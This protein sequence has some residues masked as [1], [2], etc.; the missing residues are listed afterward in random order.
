M[1]YTGTIWRPPYEASSLLLE[2][3]AG[4]THH[5]CKFCTLYDGLLFRFRM[6]PMEDIEA[7]L[8]EAQGMY[9]RFP[10]RKAARTFLTGAN[11]FVLEYGRL[12]E[13][14]GLVHKYFPGMGSIGSFARVTD[15]ALK[16][17]GELAAL[18]KAGYD[19]LT[20]GIETADD[21]ALRFMDKGYLAA[22]ILKQCGRLDQAGIRY[23][24]FYLAGI[25]GAGHG[26]DGAGATA[27]V[28]NQLNPM[29][30]GANMLTIYPGSGLYQE[31][32]RGNWKEESETEK[33]R[34]I[35]TLVKNLEIPTEFAALGASNA[36]QIQGTLPKDRG[37]LL[38]FLDDV[39]ENVGED[40]LRRYRE[41][42]RHL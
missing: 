8:K 11:P 38:A 7:D 42:V 33:Y 9:R 31:I 29:L 28:C 27:A 1:H 22:D 39:I 17:D 26:E 34:E 35:R 2:V 3:T 16:S 37:K 25:S 5:R 32:R 40:G 36:F 4:C 6:S 21:G 12:M 14:A 13:I 24:F 10:G 15:V 19:G 20:I 23:S 41:S 30:V 18:H